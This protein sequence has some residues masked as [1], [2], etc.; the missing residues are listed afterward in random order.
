MLLRRVSIALGFSLA[1][2]PQVGIAQNSAPKFLL[3]QALYW[4]SKGN[5]GRAA[6][7]WKN[8]FLIDAN[9]VC[10][11]YELALADIR[12]SRLDQTRIQFDEIKNI[13]QASFYLTFKDSNR[14]A[15]R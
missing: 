7:G 6:E 13:D 4:K 10:A 15:V 5:G 2:F 8:L 1:I 12:A 14:F 9:D 11:T 3:E